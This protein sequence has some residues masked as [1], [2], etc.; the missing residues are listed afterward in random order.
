LTSNP[1]ARSEPVEP[2]RALGFWSAAALVVGHTIGVGIFLTPAQLVGA[3]ASPAA[4]LG[5]L[6]ATGGL[7]LAGALTFGELAS[8]YPQA[9]GLYVYLRRAWGERTAFLYGW[10]CLL[11]MDPGVT[12]ALVLGLTPYLV[13]LSPA[14]A[15]HERAVGVG[16]IWAL[17][18]ANM[19][20]LR[21]SSRFLNGLTAV[22]AISLAGFVAAAFGIGRGSWAHFSP[23]WE[24]RAG[25]PPATEALALAVIGAFYSFG[26]F[27][28]ASRVAGEVRNP[29]R[30]LPRALAA[31]V[32]AVTAAYVL[33]TLAFI[34]L[35]PPSE[36]ATPSDF[37]RRAGTALLGPS[38]PPALAA[39]VI[40]SVLA[41]AM[42][43]LLMAPR[44]YLA[45]SRDGLFPDALAR[46]DR[47]TG[48]PARAT[49]L[50]AAI[51]TLY[52]LSGTF[53]QIV[54][55][56]LCPTLLL[57]ALAAAALFAI[58]RTEA[59]GA[60]FRAPGFPA[61]PA[62]FVLLL[63]A[64][65]GLTAVARPIPA[66]AGF[67]LVLLGLPAHRALEARRRRREMLKGDSR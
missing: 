17:A 57:V 64:V 19:A 38:G 31:G 15:G 21:P 53:P 7:V 61:T 44:L 11:V 6:I 24:R 26:G 27:W 59:A 47:R 33:T 37:A 23:F 66:L 45:M 63:L 65:V 8:R 40:L 52:V 16:L 60:S 58:R 25:A 20:G 67:A 39:V 42:A 2:P 50:L 13:A 48:S 56:F 41:S 28:E 49:A 62:L 4:T 30:T 43:L 18:L 9:G 5:L 12:A 1:T 46:L 14:L 3:L 55:L 34:Y 22:K 29:S 54:A 51:A 32:L 36:A 10:L 35:V